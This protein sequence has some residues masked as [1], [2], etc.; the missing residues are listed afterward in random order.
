MLSLPLN[1]PAIRIVGNAV[2]LL[3]SDVLSRAATLVLYVLVARYLDVR[4]FGQLSLALT[5][6]YCFQIFAVLGLP[7]LLTREIARRPTLTGAYV[8]AGGVVAL[9][10]AL[11]A[12]AV[13]TGFV[14]LMGY[15]ADT[16]RIILLLA[17][18]LVPYALSSICE[19]AFRG[20]ERMHLIAVAN[21]PMNVANIVVAFLLLQRGYGLF[22]T[23]LLLVASRIVILVVEVALIWRYIPDARPCWDQRIMWTTVPSTLPFLGIDGLIALWSSLNVILLSK[24]SG[25]AEVALF[26]AASQLL[27]PVM[28]LNDSITVSAFPV[29]CRKFGAADQ[30]DGKRAADHLTRLLMAV[31]VPGAVGLYCLADSLLLA[32]YGSR[33]FAAAALALR[34]MTPVIILRAVTGSLGQTLLA[35]KKEKTTLRIVAVD[36]AVAFTVGLVCIY[37][38]GVVGAAIAT[39][40]TKLV[41]GIQHMLAIKDLMPKVRWARLAWRPL[42]ASAAMVAV[43]FASAMYGL[44]VQTLAG[45]AS[46]VALIALLTV[47]GG[48]VAARA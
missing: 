21:L 5:L 25:E 43:L 9:I 40:L 44:I 26:T 32:V 47:Y 24:L 17:L 4:A 20:R 6:F 41:D 2:S 13:L 48:P 38:Y 1:R 46:Y 33:D 3:T 8:L 31:A 22:E 10:G 23:G 29:L 37:E 15:P 45:A 36:T 18:G 16:S 39:L 12:I 35:G 42:V 34:V 7:T 30:A 19:A 14:W 28:L 27:V 11:L